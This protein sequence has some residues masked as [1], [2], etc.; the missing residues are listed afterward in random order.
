MLNHIY[1]NKDEEKLS[2]G[3]N[4]PKNNNEK[5]DYQFI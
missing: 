1:L 3:N 5:K 4:K 2:I